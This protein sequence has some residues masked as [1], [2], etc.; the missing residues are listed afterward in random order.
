MERL[1]KAASPLG[2][3]A[4]EFDVET[5]R[6]LGNFPQ[7]FSHLALVEAAAESSSGEPRGRG[8]IMTRDRAGSSPLPSEAVLVTSPHAG[9]SRKLARAR[10]A[11][12]KHES[13][14]RRSSRSRT[15]IDC[16][17]YCV[18]RTGRHDW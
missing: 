14:W 8:R 18:R 7:A 15:S 2:L 16:L 9:R 17:S 12:D 3:Y 4:E 6:H 1:V 5:G 10:R 13:V 11:L